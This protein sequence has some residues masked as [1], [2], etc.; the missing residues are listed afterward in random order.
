MR[1]SQEEDHYPYKKKI[2]GFVFLTSVELRREEECGVYVRQ[3]FKKYEIEIDIGPKFVKNNGSD[4][5]GTREDGVRMD[6]ITS[7]EN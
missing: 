6:L 2:N 5:V 3:V 4:V 7:T 1:K